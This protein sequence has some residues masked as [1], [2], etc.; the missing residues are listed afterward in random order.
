M[1]AKTDKQRG[2]SLFLLLPY[3]NDVDIWNMQYARALREKGGEVK[4]I[5]F[6]NDVHEIGR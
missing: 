6:P 5:V 1:K 4:V 2:N 3:L